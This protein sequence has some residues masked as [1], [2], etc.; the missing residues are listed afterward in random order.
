MKTKPQTQHQMQQAADARVN[1]VCK[2]FNEIQSGDNPLT[3]D[4]VRRLIQKRPEMYGVLE[5]WAR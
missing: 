2:A 1:N 4:E 3:P 5:A